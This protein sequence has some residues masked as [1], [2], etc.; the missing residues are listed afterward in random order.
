VEIL[1]TYLN[2]IYLGQRG[3]RGIFGVWEGAQ[4][5]FGKEPRDLL[6]GEAA[7]LAGLIRAPGHL[8]PA[9][10]PEPAKRRRDEVLRALLENGDI[11][12]EE[13]H[14]AL[15]EP[16]PERAASTAATGAPYFVD[17]V[18]GEIEAQYPLNTLTSE[19]F[20]IFTTLD[21]SL[22]REGERAVA[23]GLTAL[24]KRHPALTKKPEP[25]EAALLAIQPRTGEIKAMVGGR[26]YAR[27]QFNRVTDA[28]RQP[29]SVFKPIVFLAALE[30]E[31]QKGGRQFL[32]TRRIADTPFTWTYDGRSWSPENYKGEYHGDVTLRQAL[33]LSLNSA[34][35]RMAQE[36]GLDHIHDVAV[37]LGL[38]EGLPKVPAMVLGGVE[39]TVYEVA[40]AF[41]TIANLGFRAETSAIR[42]VLDGEG[43]PIT[44]ASLGASQAVS[45]RV[46]YLVTNLMQGVFDRGTA[47][48]ARTAGIEFP[49]AGKTG[50]T[51]EGRD[52]WFVG[53]TPD[54][55][56]IVWVGFDRNDVVGLSGAQAAL[57]IWIDF[58]RAA[59]VGLPGTSFLVPPGIQTVTIDP[60]S[61]ALATTR[62]PERFDESFFDSEAPTEPCPLHPETGLP[63]PGSR[64]PAGEP[65]PPVARSP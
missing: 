50:T 2:E 43:N 47:K 29:G 35:A 15:D 38:P 3:S 41:A 27:S 39:V 46:A 24:E 55:L 49:A 4:F 42:A 8:A 21:P 23:N 14:Q 62:C 16:L 11:T 34:T 33:E 61:G 58:M 56:V 45:P 37:R 18:R 59:T 63:A 17:Y 5:Y 6:I 13:Y 1:E 52:T 57:P 19:G 36:V 7:M 12:T 40:Q 64:L 26:S 30:E 28:E 20:R 32:P 53:F 25:L 48:L 44:R 51:N 9:K 22:Q 10:N 65:L 60:A 54:L 31:E